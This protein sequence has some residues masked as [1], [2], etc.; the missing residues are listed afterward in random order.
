[1]SKINQRLGL[2]RRIKDYLDLNT[3]CMLY[4][5]LVLPLFDYGD[6]IWGDKNNLGLMNSLQVLQN[7]AAN[8]ILDKHPRYSSTEALQELKW[9]TLVT[10]RHNNRCTFIFKCMHGL[11]DFDF[12]LTKNED[13]H[14]HNTRQR[15]NLHLPRAKTN[16]GRQRPTYQAIV[17]FNNL[18]QKLKDATLLSNFKNLLKRR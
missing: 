8:L 15:S 2:L 14:H 7:K 3:R 6:V 16:K 4:T 10:R 13:I 12:N 5:S 11:I 18:E 1:M 17:D 9:S